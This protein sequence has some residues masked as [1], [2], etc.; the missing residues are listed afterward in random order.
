MGSTASV[1]LMVLIGLPVKPLSGAS[2]ASTAV[3]SS[4]IYCTSFI[5]LPALWPLEGVS[6]FDPFRFFGLCGPSLLGNGQMAA[7]T[8]RINYGAM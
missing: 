1:V 5:V 7:Q 6:V 3:I 2:S 8:V 4:V